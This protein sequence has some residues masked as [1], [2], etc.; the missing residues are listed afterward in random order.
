[1]VDKKAFYIA[2]SVNKLKL[3]QIRFEDGCDVKSDIIIILPKE[4]HPNDDYSSA[5]I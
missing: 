5:T 4:Q 1:M 2:F 3:F